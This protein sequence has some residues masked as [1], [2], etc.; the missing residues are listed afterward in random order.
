MGILLN[1]KN[2]FLFLSASV[3]DL[4]RLHTPIA[5]FA[6]HP[7]GGFE[8]PPDSRGVAFARRPGVGLDRRSAGEGDR[9]S[10]RGNTE[11]WARLSATA[12]WAFGFGDGD[13]GVQLL[14]WRS[15]FGFGGF[16]VAAI[17]LSRIFL[18][19]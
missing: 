17:C 1:K 7:I 2:S 4:V 13:L 18:G 14:A 19:F 8:S 3:C 10:R 6:G 15:G 9:A 12:I 16:L 11:I 5:G